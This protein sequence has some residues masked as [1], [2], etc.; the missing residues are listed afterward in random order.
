MRL[1]LSVK[2]NME[3]VVA[4]LFLTP[5]INFYLANFLDMYGIH[6]ATPFIYSVAVFL[7]SVSYGQTL[8]TRRGML[9]TWI[10]I[11]LIVSSALVNSQ[12]LGHM[13][14]LQEKLVRVKH[15][16]G[17]FASTHQAFY[18]TANRASFMNKNKFEEYERDNNDFSP[19]IGNDALIKAGVHIDD[20]TVITRGA[21]VTKDILNYAIS[22]GVMMLTG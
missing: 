6:T 3:L 10:I 2:W 16:F 9:F 14:R 5:Q 12:V 15:P 19:V 4:W 22:G 17:G 1:K 11:L 8:K 20:G 7:G 18:F 21:V 13:N